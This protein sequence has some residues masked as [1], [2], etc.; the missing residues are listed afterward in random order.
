MEKEDRAINCLDRRDPAALFEHYL[1][2]LVLVGFYG[3]DWARRLFVQTHR[4]ALGGYSGYLLHLSEE[5]L[6]MAFADAL[7]AQEGRWPE[8]LMGFRLAVPPAPPLRR[9]DAWSVWERLQEYRPAGLAL[10]PICGM[11]VDP[12]AAPYSARHNFR[13]VYFCCPR[14]RAAFVPATPNVPEAVALPFGRNE[15]LPTS[16]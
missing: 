1:R 4:G 8:T 5:H 15:E 7:T 3:D 16:A 12:Q 9:T 11:F 14:C 13:T 2:Q 10:D 6:L